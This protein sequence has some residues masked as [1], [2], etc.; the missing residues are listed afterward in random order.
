MS[1][2]QVS[3]HLYKSQSQSSDRGLP[4]HPA[5]LR[6]S[7]ASQEPDGQRS[8]FASPTN[9]ICTPMRD[10][11]GDSYYGKSIAPS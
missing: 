11:L 6:H 5:Y 8:P 10:G 3:V 2:A 1:D 9:R 4:P 7:D